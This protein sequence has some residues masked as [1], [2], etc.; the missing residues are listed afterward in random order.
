ML[1]CVFRW[2][3]SLVCYYFHRSYCSVWNINESW[4]RMAEVQTHTHT[5]IHFLLRRRKKWRLLESL[6]LKIENRKTSDKFKKKNILIIFI[7]FSSFFYLPPLLSTRQLWPVRV[8]MLSGISHSHGIFLYTISRLP[9]SRLF[10]HLFFPIC[11]LDSCV[12]AMPE[13]WIL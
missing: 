4:K 10:V 8:Y 5:H 6:F 7:V 1:R 3:R 2:R 13:H 9:S 12:I 11:S